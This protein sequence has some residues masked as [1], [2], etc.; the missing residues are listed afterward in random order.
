IFY[1][2]DRYYFQ[3]EVIKTSSKEKLNFAI[4]GKFNLIF[5][6]LVPTAI[7]LSGKIHLKEVNFLGIERPL[8]EWLRD[9]FLVILALL[10]YLLTPSKIRHKNEF[11]F[12]PIKE[13]AILFF[14]IFI[15]MIPAIS[16]LQAGEKGALR[17]VIEKL[18]GPASYFWLTGSLSAFLDNAPTYLTFL[19]SCIGKFYPGIPEKEA[20]L[21]LLKEHPNYLLAISCGAVFFGAA[22][23]IGNAPNFMVRSIA[24][25][26]GIT[27]PSFFGYL[28]KYSLPLLIPVFI[29][30]T[31]IFFRG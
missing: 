12:F 30:I 28:F 13:V 27:M 25:E 9:I 11:T 22:T 17:F 26:K 1:F 21:K 2:I 14:G 15:S 20:I 5:L 10:S 7:L 29:L 31:I 6:L 19:S 8:Q 3:K 18:A 23:Y 4:E 24:E 16:I